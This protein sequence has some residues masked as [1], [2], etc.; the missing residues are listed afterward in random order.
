MDGASKGLRRSAHPGDGAARA[1]GA[2]R[3]PQYQDRRPRRAVPPA[4]PNAA[5]DEERTS[6]ERAPRRARRSRRG[7]FG[8]SGAPPELGWKVSVPPGRNESRRTLAVR[9]HARWERVDP[10]P[11]PDPRTARRAHRGRRFAAAGPAGRHLPEQ[12]RLS[13]GAATPCRAREPD[14]GAARSSWRDVA[15]VVRSRVPDASLLCRL[16]S[17]RRAGQGSPDRAE[18]SARLAGAAACAPCSHG[19]RGRDAGAGVRAHEAVGR[20]SRTWHG[21]GCRDRWRH[22]RGRPRHRHAASVS[23]AECSRGCPGTAYA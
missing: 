15:D 16:V 17:R 20:G 22:V 21:G 14:A 5:Q 10:R 11:S 7:V 9:S 6:G 8:R 18:R 23:R 1:R 13:V 4:P 12:D 3:A 19:P 2:E